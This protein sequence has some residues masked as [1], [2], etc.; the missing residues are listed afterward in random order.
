M[1]VRRSDEG[2]AWHPTGEDWQRCRHEMCRHR[3]FSPLILRCG[4]QSHS[5]ATVRYAHGHKQPCNGFT[6]RDGGSLHAIA[7]RLAVL[8]ACGSALYGRP[9]A[10]RFPF[11]ISRLTGSHSL[12][13]THCQP[14]YMV[15]AV[16]A[17]AGLAAC[18]PAR[19]CAEPVVPGSAG[20]DAYR[21]T[22]PRYRLTRLDVVSFVTE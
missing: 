10:H 12:I 16:Q 11:R 8:T 7:C 21:G 15:A 3:H 2:R 19:P 22:R 18:S 1:A 4:I 13:T 14:P 6:R 9:F 5:I 20:A 17:A